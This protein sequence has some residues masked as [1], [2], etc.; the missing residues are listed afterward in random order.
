MDLCDPCLWARDILWNHL[1][2]DFFFVT[3]WGNQLS[4]IR[5]DRTE[6]L[7]VGSKLR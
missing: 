7:K 6:K 5:V 1:H 4:Q 3:W 2:T